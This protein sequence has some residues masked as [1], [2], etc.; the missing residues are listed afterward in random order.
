MVGI[1]LGTW[2]PTAGAKKM[3]VAFE[4]SEETLR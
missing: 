4:N 1:W 2:R 3:D